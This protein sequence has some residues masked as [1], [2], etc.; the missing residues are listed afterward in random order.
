MHFLKSQPNADSLEEIFRFQV[1]FS[2]PNPTSLKEMRDKRFVKIKMV[3]L[4]PGICPK[5]E[6]AL[7]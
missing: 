7:S 4:I 2:S 3:D 6:R 1:Y 5:R